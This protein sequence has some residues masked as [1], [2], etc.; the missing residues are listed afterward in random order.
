MNSFIVTLNSDKKEV[1]IL[2]EN[3]IVLDGRE[4]NTQ[5]T[6][7][8]PNSYLFKVGNKIYEAV[9]TKLDQEK[10]G[11]LIDG[12]YYE[13]V[14]RSKLREKAS[15]FLNKKEKQSRH[16][17]VRAPMPGLILK[18]NKK[19]GD[20]VSIGESLLVLEAMKM[21]N[22]IRSPASGKIKEINKQEG[23]SVEKDELILSIEQ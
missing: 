1:K 5:L 7:F 10:F 19:I 11:L 2:D 3:R 23:M 20:E 15:E 6:E 17:I 9:I 22:D 18:I 14:V 21:E 8:T 13:V 16:D 4:I 12:Y